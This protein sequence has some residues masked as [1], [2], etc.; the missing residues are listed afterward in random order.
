MKIAVAFR[1]DTLLNFE[2]Q[3]AEFENLVCKNEQ[4]PRLG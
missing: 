1:V 4:C 3:F 2:Q